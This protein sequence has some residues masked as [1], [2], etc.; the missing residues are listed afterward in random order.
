MG[1]LYSQTVIHAAP[2]AF[3][4]EAPIRNGIVTLEEGLRV[5]ARILGE[6]ALEAAMECVVLRYTDGPLFGFRAAA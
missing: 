4:R 2:T 3:A 6:P 5:A 1:K